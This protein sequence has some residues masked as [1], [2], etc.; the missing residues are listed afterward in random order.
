V[1]RGLA[2]A[3]VWSGGLALVSFAVPAFVLGPVPAAVLGLVAYLALLA[4]LRPP[5]LVRA[6]AYVRAL[7]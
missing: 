7:G 6:W 4:V 2:T 3:S 5:G 1:G